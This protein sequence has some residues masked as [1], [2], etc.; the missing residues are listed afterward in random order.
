MPRWFVGQ[1]GM[2]VTV[3]LIDGVLTDWDGVDASSFTTASFVRTTD[4]KFF[5]SIGTS[6]L[7]HLQTPPASLTQTGITWSAV[8]D[9][10]RA[11]VTLAVWSGVAT[12]S[13]SDPLTIDFAGT[14]QRSATWSI[15]RVANTTGIVQ[16][17]AAQ[18]QPA[19]GNWLDAPLGA[20][21]GVVL[22]SYSTSS[23]PPTA[24]A[25]TGYSSF[26]VA[27]AN[28]PNHKLGIFKAIPGVLPAGVQQPSGWGE[29]MLAI[30]VELGT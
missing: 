18:G 21:G 4:Q 2:G 28:S 16:S 5:A 30:A 11:G 13:G 27:Q 26:A 25:R 15:T 19:A 9:I 23:E 7:A 24:A 20:V 10:T 17:A 29:D 1:I 3:P 8:T 6:D 14:T 22:L 12:S